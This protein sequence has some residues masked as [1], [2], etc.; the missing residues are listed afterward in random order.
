MCLNLVLQLVSVAIFVI[1][2]VS[3]LH[4]KLILPVTESAITRSGNVAGL[5]YLLALLTAVLRLRRRTGG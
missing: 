1:K 5:W 4:K 2:M 3:I